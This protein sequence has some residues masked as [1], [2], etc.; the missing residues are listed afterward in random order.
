MRR[1]LLSVFALLTITLFAGSAFASVTVSNQDSNRYDVLIASSD[2]CFSGTHTSIGG[3]TTTS[4]SA[5]WFCLNEKK[6]AFKIEDG[7]SYIIKNG[8]IKAK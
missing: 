6:P 8:K 2:S 5:G 4:F 7:K 3:N 1:N